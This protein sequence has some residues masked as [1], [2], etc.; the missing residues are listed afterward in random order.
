M[1]IHIR[2]KSFLTVSCYIQTMPLMVVTYSRVPTNR[3]LG[4]G[5][6]ITYRAKT[7]NYIREGKI[8]GGG[9]G[10]AEG[11]GGGDYSESRV[12]WEA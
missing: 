9:G 6:E 11:T 10:E 5:I 4:V 8:I 2:A 3:G 1:F 7:K 12:R